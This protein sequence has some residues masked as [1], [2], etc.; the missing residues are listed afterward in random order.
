MTW[1]LATRSRGKRR[2]WAALWPE[3]LLDLATLGVPRDPFEDELE[4]GSTFLAN[5]RAKARYFAAR[6]GHPTLAED[7]GLCVLA[8]GGAPGP[9]AKL[10]AGE[11]GVDGAEA[12]AANRAWLLWV[13]GDLPLEA[14]EAFY[15]CT[16]V[17]RDP[18]G[19]EIVAEGRTW[20]RILLAPR[21]HGGFGYDPLFWS[22]DLGCTF[23]EAS[24]EAKNAVSHRARAVRA[25][26][27]ALARHVDTSSP[28][29]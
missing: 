25:L 24:L 19:R 2:E 15:H 9:D 12:E 14:R 20:G 17:A 18:D 13:L 26:R 6:T 16:L 27:R 22:E 3:P 8:L 7:S 1:L 29:P 5:A 4:R 11:T 28:A 23:A 21:G 10:F